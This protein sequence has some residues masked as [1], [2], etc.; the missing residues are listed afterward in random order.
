[1]AAGLLTTVAAAAQDPFAK[2]AEQFAQKPDDYES[3]YCFYQVTFEKSLWDEGARL[4]D[5]LIAKSP[6]N[7]WLPLAYGHVYRSR[8]PKR[9]EA[10]YRQ[11]ADGFQRRG[12]VEGEILARSNLSN[13]L[14]PKGRLDDAARETARVAALGRSSTDPLLK[15]RAWTL[16]ATRV[17]DSGGDLS[18]AYTLL[19]QTEG[20]IFPDGPYRLKRSTLNSLGLVAFRLGRLDEA[21]SV[22]HKLDALAAAEGEGLAQANAQYNILNTSS[23]KETLLPSPG[24]KDR[25]MRLA[26]R[27]LATAIAAQNRDMTLKTHRA[28]AE[29]LTKEPGAQAKALRHV[30]G[31]LDLAVTL[32]QAQD[33]AVCSWV[34]AWILRDSAP[35]DAR[36]AELRAL[37]ATERSRNPRTQA[38]SARRKM[39]LSWET[40]SRQ[41]AIQDSLAA[42][43]SVETLRSLQDDSDGSAEQ[44]STWTSDYLWLSGRLLQDGQDGDVDLAFS[45]TERMRA[46]SLLDQM[47][48]SHT[49]LN[50]K[51]PAVQNRR[52]AL[53]RI[54]AVQRRLMDPGLG[55]AQRREALDQLQDLELRER[56]ARRLVGIAFPTDTSAP[57][58]ASVR[59]LQ[60]SLAANEALLSFQVGLW[61]TYEKEFGG[62]S[63]L[64]A[65]TKQ[66][67]TVH[68]LPDRTEFAPIVP[69][70]AGL[71]ARADGLDE[72]S[73][74]RLYALLLAEALRR[75]PPGIDR[76]IIIPDGP[77]HQLPFDALKGGPD[78][79][80]LATRYELMVEPSATVWR[81]WREKA[82]RAVT[83]RTL[84]FADPVLDAGG[85]RDAPE[86]NATL[87]RG[88]RLGRLPHARRESRAI[89]R[90]LGSVDALVGSR[91]SE[92]ALKDRDLRNYDILHFAVHAIADE[93]RPE[94]SSVLLAPGAANEDGLLQSREIE[95]LDLEGRIVVLS[96]CQTAAGTI[97]SGEGVLSLAR[98][99]F[100][101]GAAAVVGTRW[102][103]RDADAASLFDTFYQELGDGAS[104]SEALKAAKAAA[105]AANRPA[106]AWAS[107]VLLGN[108]D[109]RPFPGGRPPTPP[110]AQSP[111]AAFALFVLPLAALIWFIAH[112]PRSR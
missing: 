74:G 4:F 105:I 46:R 73:A 65:L 21:L 36:A 13:F 30:E 107:L 112:R 80:A 108:G 81:H 78:G 38:Y 42:I 101:A 104:L 17:Q 19:K 97:V 62:G 50:P 53:E 14:F 26:E 22:F 25:L 95:G 12:H 109:F 32:R 61:E 39:H 55:D 94:R 29:L 102:P 103:I 63:W 106:A 51:D 3:A 67:R 16:E 44:F 58:F 59:G 40:R 31:C 85:T 56:E 69:M 18:R 9:A 47:E 91:A 35:K 70:F 96:A 48:R 75:L 86:R 8:D 82:A 49:L 84:A 79:A 11:S 52:A 28:L 41:Q 83:H 20:K 43:D 10:L 64:I 87:E 66:Q 5:G 1:M 98:A 2:C 92:K 6:E 111:A 90:H 45:I 100:G 37:D 72:R 71:L 33:E 15:A 27:S 68:R 77:L 54:A 110:R 34:Q 93:A 23:L 7:L 99:F 88:L 76:L 57:A 60:E 24:G 89:G